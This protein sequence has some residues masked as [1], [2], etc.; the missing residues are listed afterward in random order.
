MGTL[1]QHFEFHANIFISH[2]SIR[3][4]F[5]VLSF[6]SYLIASVQP[7]FCA[8]FFF[9]WLFDG[10]GKVESPMVTGHLPSFLS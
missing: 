4:G 3:H 8:H 7:F 10:K 1:E 6:F 2:T 5:F 9:K